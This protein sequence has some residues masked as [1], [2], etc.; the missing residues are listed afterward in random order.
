MLKKGKA[1]TPEA[2]T[3]SAAEE[4]KDVVLSERAVSI[5]PAVV[6]I[7]VPPPAAALRLA[8]TALKN[9][10]VPPSMPIL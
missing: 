6:K 4:N 8:R 2:T 7:S 1:E 9:G 3:A 5:L 10:S